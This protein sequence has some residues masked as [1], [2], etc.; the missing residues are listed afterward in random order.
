MSTWRAVLEH[1]AFDL[2][3]PLIQHHVVNTLGW[4][5]LRPLQASAVRPV[6]DGDDALLLAPTAGGKTEAAIFPLL[7]RMA[8]HRWRGTTVL[9]IC[10]LRALLNN[11]EPRISA[12]TAWMG[13]ATGLRHGDTGRTERQRLAIDHP[14]VLLT[15]PESL[16][17]M[18]VSTTI[19]P[20]I[21]LSD[22]RSVVI[23][24]I[25]A[26]AGDDRGWHLLAVLERIA[27][28]AGCRLQRVG[29]SATV[30]NAEE[31]LRWMQGGTQVPRPG[32]VIN[33]P[34]ET[35]VTPDVQLDFV[36]SVT[37]AA[38]IISS[39]HQGEK[40]LIFADTRARVEEL[41][42][43]LRQHGVETYVSHSSLAATERRRA[44]QAFATA[45]NCVIVSTSTLELGIDVGDLDRVIQ[46]G[47]PTTVSSFLQRLG[48]TGRRLGSSR[49]MLLL[50]TSDD[51]LVQAAGILLL[52]G[53][54]YVEP[55]VPPPSPRHVLAQQLLASALQE[56][57]VGRWDW[58]EPLTALEL[59]SP[60]ETEQITAWMLESGHLDQDAEML[61]VGPEAE[62]A[63]GHRH[64][65]EVL[66]IFS[67]APQFMIVNGRREIGSVD[68]YVL[69]RKVVGPRVI[70]LA[71]QG[72]LVTAVDWS[73]RRAY[74]EIAD[75]RGAARWISVSQPQA[76][77]L[78]QAQRRVLLGKV[79]AGVLLT[80]RA[81]EQLPRARAES[82]GRVEADCTLIN[83][84]N[85]RTRWWT[86]AGGRANAILTAALESVDA[87]L[88]DDEYVY[89]NRQIG[90]RSRVSAADLRRT[91][92][93]LDRQICSD[94]S[95][96][97]PFVT[98]RAL[99]Q[100]KFSD[101]L[102]PHLARKT[103]EERLSDPIGARAVLSQP[104]STVI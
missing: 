72:W 75:T 97:T 22:V 23:D 16:E 71:G 28:L 18:L 8:E 27:K 104:I 99:K 78:V 89:D 19:D 90:L 68:P 3:H 49:N 4:G 62:R 60:T 95:S 64:F 1:Q 20:R 9:Y 12:Y 74:V 98:D 59:A 47:A 86:W 45:R 92:H 46:V 43:L 69:I 29:L 67:S 66:S 14:D 77:S 96:V 32:L 15:T 17:A 54:S 73:R 102:P 5:E 101:L 51:E 56:R 34:N 35:P 55:V 93:A 103:L 21:L 57:Q 53:E 33:P 41:A 81:Q 87:S 42:T 52:W 44:E 7:T 31:L 94:L 40:R 84:E 65:M 63:Y 61:F 83:T 25:H 79:P 10:P 50:A 88:I 6:L 37:N 2:L 80:Q 11:L 38:K 36:G 30:G 70:A 58:S 76:F 91:V 48:R 39:I 24:E 100:L 13:R 82:S 85:G 26:F